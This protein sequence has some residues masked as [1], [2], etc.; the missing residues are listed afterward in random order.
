MNEYI[1]YTDEGHT[2]APNEDVE[3]ENCQVIGRAFGRTEDEARENLLKEN[4]WILE[5]GFSTN[6][7]IVKQLLT[8]EMRNDISRIVEWL[9]ASDNVCIDVNDNND[10]S[11]FNALRRLK[12]I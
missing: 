4:L 1:F 7:F 11:V 6:E 10:N 9:F 5:A 2:D 3:I 8:D 12:G